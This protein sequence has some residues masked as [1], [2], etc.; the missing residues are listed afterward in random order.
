MN[1]KHRITNF[2]VK[3][4]TTTGLIAIICI[5]SSCGNNQEDGLIRINAD[6]KITKKLDDYIS[7]IEI[8]PLVTIEEAILRNYWKV[9]EYDNKYYVQDRSNGLYVF[10]M[11]G[12]YL[13]KIGNHGNGPGE[14]IYI[15]DFQIDPFTGN[16]EILEPT[17]RIKVYNLAGEFLHHYGKRYQEVSYFYIV[18]EDLVLLSHNIFSPTLNLYS[19]K[20]DSVIRSF[21]GFERDFMIFRPVRP[22]AHYYVYN[23][24]LYIHHG[25]TNDIYKLDNNQ[26]Y[27]VRELDFG[28]N[29]FTIDDYDWEFAVSDKEVGKDFIDRKY[30]YAFR[31]DFENDRYMIKK[32]CFR[33][34]ILLLIY[35]KRKDEYEI[36][37]DLPGCMR[38]L[39]GDA[40]RYND[41]LNN[42]LPDAGETGTRL[43]EVLNWDSGDEYVLGSIN[44]QTKARYINPAILDEE[45]LDRYNK[46]NLNDN[47]ALVKIYFKNQ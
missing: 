18:D 25:Y 13:Y 26:L 20:A 32:L 1:I 42:E 33:N 9:V 47:P 19:R 34:D 27:P 14:Y 29:T 4:W 24:E 7:H 35:D 5:F 41:Y 16:I 45:N 38:Y 10:N 3:A 30:V 23:D 36:L 17:G 15:A 12:E 31:D 21:L 28:A 37:H 2:E 43:P 46:M 8:I 44:S 22:D 39:F 6:K 40:R 11:R